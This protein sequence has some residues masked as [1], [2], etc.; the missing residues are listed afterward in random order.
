MQ[1]KIVIYLAQ[2][3]I[4]IAECLDQIKMQEIRIKMADFHLVQILMREE[5]GFL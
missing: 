2:I 5:E 1:T 4:R 3:Q